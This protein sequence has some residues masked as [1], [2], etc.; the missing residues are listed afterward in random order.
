VSKTSQ[1]QPIIMII[2]EEKEPEPPAG[3]V[4]PLLLSITSN[5]TLAAQQNFPC[6]PAPF[7]TRYQMCRMLV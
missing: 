1:D 2:S 4:F 5:F 7:Q 6:R 3:F